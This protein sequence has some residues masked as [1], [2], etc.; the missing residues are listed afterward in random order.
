VEHD[1]DHLAIPRLVGILHGAT[2]VDTRDAK[3]AQ[4]P[5]ALQYGRGANGAAGGAIHWRKLQIREL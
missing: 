5:I 3:F 2:T 4:G 1:R